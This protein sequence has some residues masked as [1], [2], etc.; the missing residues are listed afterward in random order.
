MAKLVKEFTRIIKNEKVLFRMKDFQPI[1]T[2]LEKLGKLNIKGK[3]NIEY[4]MVFDRIYI[5][6]QYLFN[7]SDLIGSLFPYGYFKQTD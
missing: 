6:A 3:F 7:G 2:V 5:A 1:D 4:V